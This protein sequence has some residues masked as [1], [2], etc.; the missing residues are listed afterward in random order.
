MRGIV[1]AQIDAQGPA[2]GR[3]LLDVEHLEPVAA[4]QPVDGNERKIREMLMIDRVELVVLDQSF[5]MRE[6]E[7]DDSVRS[8]QVGHSRRKVIEIRNL[9]QHIVADDK[10]SF[11]S[12]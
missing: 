2:M 10:I 1:A 8:Q 3:K 11:A 5:E 9:R 4:S 7:R 12:F 6:L